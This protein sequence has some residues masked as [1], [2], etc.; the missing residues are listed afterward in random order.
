MDAVIREVH[1]M[2][3][4][5]LTVILIIAL[6]IPSFI[7]VGYYSSTKKEPEN[8]SNVSVLSI[9]DLNGTKWNFSSDDEGEKRIESTKM[10]NMFINM[11]KNA[12]P[13]ASLPEAMEGKSF[14]LVSLKSFGNESVYQYYF[15][16][17]PADAYIVDSSAAVF[18]ISEAEATEF[19][20]TQYSASLYGSTTTPRLIVA[21]TYIDPAVWVWNYET[22]DGSYLPLD[23]TEFVSNDVRSCTIDDGLKIGF[24]DMP[25]YVKITVKSGDEIIFDDSIEKIGELTL[26]GAN[27]FDITVAAEWYQSE[28]KSYYGSASYRFTG[29]I[30]DPAVFYLGQTSVE[31]GKFVCIGGKNVDDPSKIGFTSEPSINYTPTFFAEGDYVYALVP[32]SYELENGSDQTFT[33]T[34]TYGNVTQTMNLTVESYKYGNST[35][36]A[37]KAVEKATYTEETIKEAE[38]ALLPV[39]T[40]EVL[41][42]HAFSGKFLEDVVGAGSTDKISP[43]FGRY[44]TVSATGT[45][46]RH[47]GCDYNVKE[48][49]EVYAVNDGQV[50]YS[51]YLTATGYIVVVDHG[52]GL[53]SWYCHLSKNSVSVGDTVKKGDVIGLSGDTGFA[54]KNRTHVGLTVYDVPVSIY[55]LWNEP[56]AIPSMD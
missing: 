45:K 37:T 10:I 42:T 9:E 14:F 24:T 52:W 32:I 30:I 23:T 56:V 21:D 12:S 26:E 49:T 51:G 7:A 40:T 2:N 39:A 5:I 34:L 53:K 25:D 20:S 54:A 15:T 48:G 43:G 4:K 18:K 1:I 6:F 41:S 16:T 46:Y 28:G 55:K 44:V 3:K 13:V 27:N 33:F 31:N 22:Y 47:T 36:G 17:S 38:E 11:K 19:L 35:S 8:S 50:V 29:N